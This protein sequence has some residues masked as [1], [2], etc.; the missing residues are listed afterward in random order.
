MCPKPAGLCPIISYPTGQPAGW[1]PLGVSKLSQGRPAGSG[2]CTGGSRR[3]Q[4]GPG[5]VREGPEM[6]LEGF[7]SVWP[8]V[9][10]GH[11]SVL[12]GP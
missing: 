2:K 3:V 9:W 7:W 10:E 8:A 5:R 12:D 1:L 11:G 6:V 4:E